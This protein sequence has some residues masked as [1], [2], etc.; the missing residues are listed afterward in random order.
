MNFLPILL[1]ILFSRT[2]PREEARRIV[3]EVLFPQSTYDDR[4]S[5]PEI[6]FGEVFSA[7]D[8]K[9]ELSYGEF[10]LD[11]LDQV[12]DMALKQ[13]DFTE[14]AGSNTRIRFLDVGSGCGRLC[15]YLALSRPWDVVGIEVSP[16]HHSRAVE[17]STNA[18]A[19]G[20][21]VT[22]QHKDARH[23]GSLH[24]LSG[25]AFDNIEIL[26][27][28]DVSFCYSTAFLSDGF[29]TELEGP[30]L[31]DRWSK[32]FTD[33]CSLRSVLLTTDRAVAAS[34]KWKL[35]GSVTVPNPEVN[36]SECFIQMRLPQL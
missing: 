7:Q 35:I 26:R 25:S 31:S 28:A 16:Y 36:E 23:S 3:N 13:K 5:R 8:P 11:S 14:A 1:S 2:Y 20:Y 27:A 6:G 17:I 15:F 34:T 10:P 18:L 12:L 19:R 21:L 29:S 9:L 24:L 22:Q 33:G 32:L 4:Y 30:I